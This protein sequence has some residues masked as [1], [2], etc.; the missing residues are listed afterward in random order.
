MSPGGLDHG[1][2]WQLALEMQR[3]QALADSQKK[4][5]PKRLESSPPSTTT[6]DSNHSTTTSR[7][8]RKR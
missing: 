7:R 2:M 6:T 3:V 8:R 1:G 4:P 5:L